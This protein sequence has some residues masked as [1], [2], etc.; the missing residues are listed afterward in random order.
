MLGLV[1][2]KKKRFFTSHSA[3]VNCAV[4]A[5][6]YTHLIENQ[7]KNTMVLLKMRDSVP[8]S[9]RYSNICNVLRL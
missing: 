8:Y 9:V 3:Y 1:K 7:L 5:M 2:N 4:M 6:L